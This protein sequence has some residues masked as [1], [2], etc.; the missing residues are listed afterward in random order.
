MSILTSI[1]INSSV[2]AVFTQGFYCSCSQQLLPNQMMCSSCHM[3]TVCKQCDR[4]REGEGQRERKKE[5]PPQAVLLLAS[6]GTF[7]VKLFA[8]SLWFWVPEPA[9][10]D[11]CHPNP[12]LLQDPDT[13]PQTS[14]SVLK[15]GWGEP[16][17]RTTQSDMRAGNSSPVETLHR[18]LLD[19][20]PTA[21]RW[22]VDWERGR[23]QT[24]RRTNSGQ[25]QHLAHNHSH[26]VESWDLETG[27]AMTI[28][29][30]CP[31]LF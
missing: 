16:K 22:K 26:T 11:G 1:Q 8:D 2:W 23:G 7:S 24:G 27:E 20:Q 17:S 3:N 15:G 19:L 14:D 18:S 21:H 10:D 6:P 30:E 31:W 25:T 28:L 29:S 12:L 13:T 5:R 9:S 4:A